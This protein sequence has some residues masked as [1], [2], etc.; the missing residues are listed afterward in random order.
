MVLQA[1]AM[2]TGEINYND[3]MYRSQWLWSGE[4]DSSQIGN[5]D[6]VTRAS[7]KNIKQEGMLETVSIPNIFPYTS[8]AVLVIFIC[9][10]PI[11]IMNLFFGIAVN[12][13][14]HI[15]KLSLIHQK[16]KMVKIIWYY[17]K[18][19]DQFLIFAPSFLHKYIKK[20]LFS[21]DM[22]EVGKNRC[23]VKL[24]CH[25]TGKFVSRTLNWELKH[26]IKR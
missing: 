3:L 8:Q 4:G 24:D 11:I 7:A 19:I 20:P 17:E 9:I 10:I 2:M 15:I 25:G 26:A 14:N 21:K 12:D 13:V 23:E 22:K 1:L 6:N 5:K 16:I 18:T